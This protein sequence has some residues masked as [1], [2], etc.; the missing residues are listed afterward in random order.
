MQQGNLLFHVLF[1][2][3]CI[4]RC[5]IMLEEKQVNWKCQNVMTNL[6]EKD[7]LQ[8]QELLPTISEQLCLQRWRYHSKSRINTSQPCIPSALVIGW[9]FCCNRSLSDLFFNRNSKYAVCSFIF[10]LLCLYTG[11]E[12]ASGNCRVNKKKYLRPGTT[13]PCSCIPP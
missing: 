4:R 10:V 5:Q 12:S 2:K 13:S 1:Y 6:S 7:L 9:P 3:K 11:G 8:Q